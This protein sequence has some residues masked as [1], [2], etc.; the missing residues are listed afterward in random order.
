V[1]A[2]V[3]FDRARLRESLDFQKARS[4]GSYPAEYE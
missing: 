2:G 4:L 1:I 3:N